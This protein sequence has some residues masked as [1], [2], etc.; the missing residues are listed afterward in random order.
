M[1]S[2]TAIPRAF[3]FTHPGR[4]ATSVYSC[5]KEC[6]REFQFTHPGRGATKG[7]E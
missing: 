1:R 5:F 4:G 7:G 2:L 3:Q 6:H